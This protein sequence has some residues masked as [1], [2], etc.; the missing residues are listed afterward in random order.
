MHGVF[1]RNQKVKGIKKE[2][3]EEATKWIGGLDRI[4]KTRG[5]LKCFDFSATPFKPSGN[6]TP[7]ESLFDWIVSDFGL[8]DAI[9]SGIVKTPRVVVRD[10]ALPDAKTYKPRLYHLYNDKEV[11][12]DFNRKAEPHEPLPDLVINAYLS[13][14]FRLAG[15]KR[16]V[17]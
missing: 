11:K 17:G 5:I 7:E 15:N 9:E 1:Q 14:R 4:N 6:K 2:E 3:I 8:S 12:D 13:S 10:N 16:K